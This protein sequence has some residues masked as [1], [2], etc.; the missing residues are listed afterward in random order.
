MKLILS[1]VQN[2]G[3]LGCYIWFE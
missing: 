2:V 3:I 1:L